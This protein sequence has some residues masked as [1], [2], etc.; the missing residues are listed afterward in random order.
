MI[1]DSYLILDDCE[2]WSEK[3]CRRYL[4]EME[5]GDYLNNKDEFV[6]EDDNLDYAGWSFDS[7]IK[8]LQG[9]IHDDIT[10][11]IDHLES[12]WNVPVLDLTKDYYYSDF[13]VSF[14]SLDKNKQE[15]E[16]AV[17]KGDKRLHEEIMPIKDRTIFTFEDRLQQVVRTCKGAWET[18]EK[19]I[20][21]SN[22]DL[23]QICDSLERLVDIIECTHP[24]LDSDDK[25]EIDAIS[26]IMDNL[27]KEN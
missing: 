8:S 27:R 6:F 16:I 18:Y 14:E 17:F 7:K 5:L 26:S 10:V 24:T 2:I 13:R 21:I 23:K 9:A 25:K 19:D 1:K 20:T 11:V 12:L 4:F 3:D 22:K 15:I